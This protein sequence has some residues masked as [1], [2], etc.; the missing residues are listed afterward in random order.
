M[1]KSFL[2]YKSPNINDVLNK[3]LGKN[4]EKKQYERVAPT[5]SQK[6]EVLNRQKGKCA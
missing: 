2:D 6:N 4:K 5:N 1:A 3:S